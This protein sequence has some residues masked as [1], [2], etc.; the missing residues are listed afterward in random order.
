M[1]AQTIVNILA[2]SELMALGS[3]RKYAEQYLLCNL[4]T[5]TTLTI[6]NKLVQPLKP[7]FKMI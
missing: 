7:I 3:I 4:V 6:T 2:I 1:R 5:S